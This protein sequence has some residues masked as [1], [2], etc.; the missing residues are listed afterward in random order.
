MRKWP[1]L[2]LLAAALLNGGCESTYYSAMESVGFAKREILASRVKDARDSQE[3][4][5][6]E[7]TDALTEFGRVVSYEGGDLET[8]YNRLA[9]QLEDGE[10]AAEAVS[11]RIRDVES[12][13]DALFDEWQ[14]ELAQYSS[15]NLRTQSERQLRATRTRYGEMIGA[16][17]RA[18]SR[19][20]PALVPLRDQVL[21][22]KHNLNA[23][24]IAGL[25]GEVTRVDAQVDRLVAELDRAIAEADRFIAELEKNPG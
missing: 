13:A 3:E 25:K 18:E 9:D 16:M 5:R 21:F 23:R 22:L 7:I 20:E 24:A 17:K 1:T 15:A 2:A 8:Q 14:K 11:A 4:A 19:L 12:V 10:D 6:Q